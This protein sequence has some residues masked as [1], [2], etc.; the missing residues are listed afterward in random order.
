MNWDILIFLYLAL[1]M[2]ISSLLAVVSRN[3]VH[4]VLWVL[5]MILHQAFLLY[6]L[7]SEFLTAVQIIVYAGAVLVLFLFVVYMINLRKEERWRIFIQR[8]SLGLIVFLVFV[9]LFFKNLAFL[10]ALSPSFQAA[11]PMDLNQGTNLWWMAR[12]LYSHYLFQ[13]EIIGVIL[14]VAVLGAVFLLRKLK[15]VA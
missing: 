5:V 2:S 12:Y 1:A 4:A 6:T 10:T 7:G 3:P 14:L 15:E 8:S 9:V 11:L 13:F